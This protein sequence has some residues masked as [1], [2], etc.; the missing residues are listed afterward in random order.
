MDVKY[1]DHIDGDDVCA[2]R[3]TNQRSAASLRLSQI[4]FSNLGSARRCR[5][6]LNRQIHAG[7][8][9][10][11]FL[12]DAQCGLQLLHHSGGVVLLR[13]RDATLRHLHEIDGL[14]TVEPRIG[15]TDGNFHRHAYERRAVIERHLPAL[16]LGVHPI[17]QPRAGHMSEIGRLDA[18]ATRLVGGAAR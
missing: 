8:L 12:H 4:V 14:L 2:Q 3:G 10:L 1:F 6:P 9:A 11:V 17:R 5:G 13:P 16:D 15:P 18:S 7:G